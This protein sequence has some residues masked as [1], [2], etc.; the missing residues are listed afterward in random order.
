MEEKK[1]GLRRDAEY[2]RKEWTNM[3]N[4]EGKKEKNTKKLYKYDSFISVSWSCRLSSFT[5]DV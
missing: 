2:V 5:N 3:T 4:S 1:Y